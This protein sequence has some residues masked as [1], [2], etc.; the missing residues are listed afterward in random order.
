MPI[1]AKNNI[2]EQFF[3]LSIDMLC[4][5]NKARYFQTVNPSFS[6]ALGYKEEELLSSPV[7]D[8]IHPDDV[9]RTIREFEQ[10]GS[11]LDSLSFE[12]RYRH[13]NNHYVTFSWNSYIDPDS[14]LVYCVARDIT[15]QIKVQSK[16]SYLQN[17]LEQ[18]TV[19]A[20]TDMR[21]VITKVNR[22]FCEISGYSEEEL[23][24]NTH[25]LINSD[26]HPTAFF[27]AIWKTISSG[28][29]WSG[30]I[31]N[32]KKNGDDFFVQSILIPIFDNSNQIVNYIA[33]RQ[34]ITDKVNSEHNRVKAL[35]ILSETS[36]VAKIGGWEM[37]AATGVLS[38]TDETF[39]ILEV[40]QVDGLT[41]L[42]PEGLQL[43][44][45]T[46]QPIIE[47]AVNRALEFG[48]PYALEL[49]ASTPTGNIKWIYTNGKANYKDGKIVTL[50]GTI[51]DIHERK[52]I[53]IKYN[54]ERH[55]SI[56]SAKFSAL[57]ELSASIAHEI[58][59]PL[60][61]ISGFAELLQLTRVKSSPEDI[62][63]KSTA[64]LK[65]CDRIQ[66]IVKSLKRFSRS[67]VKSEY[68]SASLT[69]I[70]N[71]AVILT[72][73]KLAHRLVKLQCNHIENS[74]I[75]CNEIEI[76][77]VIVNLVNNAIDAVSAL[78]DKWID[79]SV[80]ET[81]LHYSISITD[82]GLGVPLDEQVSI[83]E[84]FITS[85]DSTEGTGLG[86]SIVKGILDSHGAKI[87]IDNNNENTC[88]IV[89][90][91]KLK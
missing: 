61:A 2:Y 39:R 86:L 6:R 28:K 71:E 43:F 18:E 90:F 73:P 27:S 57:G 63:E 24:G 17:A 20:E 7:I 33:I 66:H 68:T 70:I 50:S 91:P 11:E 69:N 65:S 67:D 38:W 13:K 42:L 30:T 51:Q 22:K 55:K 52:L 32:R 58:N 41:P 46:D 77:Q 64:I 15:Q 79:I 84:P 5:V 76:E 12:N 37:N 62:F 34:D 53:E 35:E 4:V 49:Q 85:K 16:L 82:A 89:D 78:S 1:N 21:G 56:I 88:F 44:I 36:A 3:K 9:D 23:L 72:T 29:V 80:T 19:Y 81:K 26:Y 8:F 31:K 14:G 40:E 54:Q 59:N 60:A 10:L 45:T 74:Q 87:S 47:K 83:F 48:E 25:K 75:L